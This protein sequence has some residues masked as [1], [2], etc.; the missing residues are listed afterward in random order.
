MEERTVIFVIWNYRIC[1]INSYFGT[2]IDSI[3]ALPQL[4]QPGFSLVIKVDRKAVKY[5]LGKG[6]SFIVESCLSK[7]TLP[8]IQ[9]GRKNIF[10]RIIKETGR[11][12]Q[13]VEQG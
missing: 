11:S 2:G 1:L 5:D 4:H 10:L 13:R 6:S 8:G 9:C 7:I 12:D 3:L